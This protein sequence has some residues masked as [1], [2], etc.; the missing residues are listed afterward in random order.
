M[1]WEWIVSRMK[2]PKRADITEGQAKVITEYLQKNF[3]SNV[4]TILPEKVMR[5][6]KKHLWR[7]DFGESDLYLD[8]IYIPRQHRE[9]IRY[10]V[11]NSSET[12]SDDILVV[13]YV[14][15]HQGVIP[16]WDIAEMATLRD[17]NGREVGARTWKVLYEDGQKHHQQGILSFPDILGEGDVVQSSMEIVIRLPGMRERIF[18]WDLSIPAF[19][20]KG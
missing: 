7:S 2:G 13:V 10:L 3:L 16:R 8:L 14:N 17:N 6:L 1:E 18:Q 12:G 9:L 5:F 15:T 11:V 4:P 19:E 20:G